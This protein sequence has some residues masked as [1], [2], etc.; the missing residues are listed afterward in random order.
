MMATQWTGNYNNARSEAECIMD[1]FE[2]KVSSVPIDE[3]LAVPA[4]LLGLTAM[5]GKEI[6]SVTSLR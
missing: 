3:H 1:N 6:S 5:R 4:Q 2:L